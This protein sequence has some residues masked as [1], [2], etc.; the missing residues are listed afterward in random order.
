MD[1][2]NRN[3]D[4]NEQFTHQRIIRDETKKLGAGTPDGND[5]RFLYAFILGGIFMGILVLPAYTFVLSK[6]WE[7]GGPTGKILVGLL[8][9]ITFFVVRFV[10]CFFLVHVH[11][12]YSQLNHVRLFEGVGQV[13]DAVVKLYPDGSIVNISAQIEESKLMQ[14]QPRIEPPKESSIDEQIMYYYGACNGQISLICQAVD[15][16][17]DDVYRVMEPVLAAAKLREQ[18]PE[19]GYLE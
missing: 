5:K 15:C 8:G 7:I 3:S 11:L 12:L 16:T 9:V 13:G 18:E 1:R 2:E 10:I 6:M 4:K 17:T 14:I 19:E